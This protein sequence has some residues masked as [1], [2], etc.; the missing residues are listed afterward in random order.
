[1]RLAWLRVVVTVSGRERWERQDHGRG[2]RMWSLST[3]G[4]EENEPRPSIA[5]R[6]DVAE[7]CLSD[8]WDIVVTNP[9][10]RDTVVVLV[11]V[12]IACC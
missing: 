3:S 1:L 10:A 5:K 12:A 2:Q 8:L 7:S 11:V 9:N 4:T 6:D